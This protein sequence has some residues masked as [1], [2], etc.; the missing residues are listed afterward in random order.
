ML[1]MEGADF[2]RKYENVFEVRG[3]FVRIKVDV[4]I[5]F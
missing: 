2:E 5:Y 3:I 1:E 4:M